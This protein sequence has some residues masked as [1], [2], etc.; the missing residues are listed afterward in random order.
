VSCKFFTYFID[1]ILIDPILCIY[2]SLK[3]SLISRGPFDEPWFIS[4]C[5]IIRGSIGINPKLGTPI[6][7]KSF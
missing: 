2:R 3:L 4:N 6:N 5:G 1:V 7:Y